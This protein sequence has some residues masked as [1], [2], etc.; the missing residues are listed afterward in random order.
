MYHLSFLPQ[1]SSDV[2]HRLNEEPWRSSTRSCNFYCVSGR[3][4]LLFEA[5]WLLAVRL[6]LEALLKLHFGYLSATVSSLLAWPAYLWSGILGE[7]QSSRSI[8]KPSKFST[9]QHQTFRTEA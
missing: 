9:R 3:L 1:P 5:D 7:G 8:N 2:L 6:A 4:R